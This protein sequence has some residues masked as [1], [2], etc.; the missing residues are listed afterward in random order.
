[1]CKSYQSFNTHRCSTK[2]D[3]EQ[4]NMETNWNK[5][6]QNFLYEI[7]IYFQFLFKEEKKIFFYTVSD[8][9]GFGPILGSN[10][11]SISCGNLPSPEGWHDTAS[12]PHP[13]GIV[14]FT[15]F[16]AELNLWILVCKW[17]IVIESLSLVLCLCS[18]SPSVVAHKRQLQFKGFCTSWLY[19][20]FCQSDGDGCTLVNTRGMA[21][22]W[23]RR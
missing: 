15:D 6:V 16:R 1:M 11:F 12:G 13:Y 20:R 9:R 18:I 3:P 21:V 8:L 2:T 23:I 5:I 4:K 14:E 10:L 19:L 22:T 7:M 17:L